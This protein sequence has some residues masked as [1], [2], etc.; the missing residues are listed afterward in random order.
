[1]SIFNSKPEDEQKHYDQLMEYLTEVNIVQYAIDNNIPTYRI[2]FVL[3]DYL[4]TIC[5]LEGKRVNE[6][7]LFINLIIEKITTLRDE[8]MDAKREDDMLNKNKDN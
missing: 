7:D 4:S 6:H 5:L 1:M 2:T 3:A 8:Y